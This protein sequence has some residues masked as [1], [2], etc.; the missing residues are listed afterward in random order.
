MSKADIIRAWRDSEYRNSLS[1]GD[2]ALIPSHPAGATEVRKDSSKGKIPISPF[3]IAY[4]C[5]WF[6]G[7]VTN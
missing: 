7:D 2:R 5:W 3:S 1:E 6:C 4:S